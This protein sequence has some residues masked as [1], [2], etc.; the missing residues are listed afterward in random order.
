MGGNSLFI[1]FSFLGRNRLHLAFQQLHAALAAG[2]IDAAGRINGHIGPTGQLQQ[3]IS[4][5]AFDLEKHFRN[6]F[7]F[8]VD[9]TLPRGKALVWCITEEF[10]DPDISHGGIA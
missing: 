8:G 5:V 7:P 2:A 10:S 1:G 6:L 3:I 9:I 4:G